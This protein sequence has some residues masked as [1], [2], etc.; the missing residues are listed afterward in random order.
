MSD[1]FVILQKRDRK[2]VGSTEGREIG[3]DKRG[4]GG[5]EFMGHVDKIIGRKSYNN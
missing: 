3:R 5:K 1:S 4:M 2:F